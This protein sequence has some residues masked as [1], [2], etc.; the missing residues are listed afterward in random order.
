MKESLGRLNIVDLFC[1]TGGFSLGAHHA[2]MDVSVAFDVDPILTSSYKRNFP[3]TKLC[4]QDVGQLT[5]QAMNAAAGKLIDGIIGGPPCQ[6]FSFIGKRSPLDPRRELLFHFFRLVEGISPKFFV[7]E[8]VQG[9][10]YGNAREVLDRSLALVAERYSIL[11]PIILDPK[12]YGAATKRPRLFVIGIHKDFGEPVAMADLSVYARSPTTVLS[13][14]G[15]LVNSEPKGIDADGFDLWHLA[16]G[17]ELSDYALA[18]RNVDNTFTGHRETSHSPAVTA[19][20]RMVSPGGKDEVGRHPRLSW[21][22]FCP[23]LRAGTGVDKGSYQSVRPI[24]PLFDRVITV[25]EGARLQGFPDAHRFHPTVWHSFRMIG[26]SVSPIISKAIFS[27]IRT[28]F[29]SAIHRVAAE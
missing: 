14:I 1:G 4:L 8:N 17:S 2:G 16:D 18:M 6:G 26:N 15:D 24:H 25:R 10:L 5:P 19:R 27:A 21:D 7:M 12:D 9:L 23:T 3:Q 22:G 11:G 29:D 13:A 28:K 20:F